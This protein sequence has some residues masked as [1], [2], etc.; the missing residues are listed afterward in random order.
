MDEA[1]FW[2]WLVGILSNGAFRNTIVIIGVLVA[3][4][5]VLSAR[6]TAR[7]KQ[8]A[9]LLFDSRTDKELVN[10]L[11][12]IAKLHED[13]NVNMRSFAQ[14][15]AG[16]SAEAEAIRYVLNHYEYVGVGVQAGIYDESM[17]KNGSYNTVIK[18]YQRA[19]PYIESVREVS[20]RPTLYQEFQW[21]AKRWEDNPIEQKKKKR[22]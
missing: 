16:E 10:G 1:G 19:K 20:G 14:K 9:D 12:L 15:G 22:R 13:C 7:K 5:S 8:A 11:R 4:V 3:V 2:S 17:L 21:L 6:A 18:L